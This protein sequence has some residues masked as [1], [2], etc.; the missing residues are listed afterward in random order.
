MYFAGMDKMVQHAKP[1]NING[2]TD[3][4]M[5]CNTVSKGWFVVMTLISLWFITFLQLKRVQN[6]RVSLIASSFFTA[7]IS[8]LF[9]I[10]GVLTLNHFIICLAVLALVMASAKWMDRGY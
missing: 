5:W 7:M 9:W 4:L 3:L 1:E 6:N 2:F 8:S 10:L